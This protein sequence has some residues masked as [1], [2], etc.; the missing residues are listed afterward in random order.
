MK[1]KLPERTAVIAFTES[2]ESMRFL[3][4][5]MM[6]NPAPTLVS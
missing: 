5:S 3:R 1:F 6:G 4:V 2:P